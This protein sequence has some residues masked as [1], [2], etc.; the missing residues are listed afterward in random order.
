MRKR[1]AQAV[2]KLRETMEFLHK[3]FHPKNRLS[4]NRRV[5]RLE[6]TGPSTTK[7]TPITDTKLTFYTL[8]PGLI[9]ETNL[10]KGLII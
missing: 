6:S 2:H 9:I 8:S 7:T 3:T 4:T 5:S 1:S 10:Y